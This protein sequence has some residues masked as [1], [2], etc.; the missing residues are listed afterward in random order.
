M[1]AAT[2]GKEAGLGMATGFKERCRYEF[3]PD[4]SAPFA[5]RGGGG[6]MT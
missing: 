2:K 4:S 3:Y 5:G 1:T 6:R